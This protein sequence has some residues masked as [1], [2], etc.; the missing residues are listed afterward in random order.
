[1]RFVVEPGNIDVMVG[2]SSDDLRLVGEFVLTG[3]VVEVLGKR[4]F[5]SKAESTR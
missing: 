5:V 4:A 2:S 3:E 1:M